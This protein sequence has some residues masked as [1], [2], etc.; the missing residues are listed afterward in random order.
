MKMSRLC[1][2][3]SLVWFNFGVLSKPSVVIIGAGP[4][5]IA[6]A[7]KLLQNGIHDI[8]ILEAEDRIGGR[9][10]SLEFGGGI[11]DL[12]AQYCHGEKG[13][14][15]YNLAKD[16]DVL[17]P[18][19]RSLQN[20]VYYSNGSKLNPELI[21]ELRQVYLKYDKNEGF[22]TKGKSL[23]EVFIQKYNSTLFPKYQNSEIEV[24]R[25]GLRFLEGYVLIHEG[26]FSWFNVSAD[27]DYVQCEGNQALIWK[28]GYKTVLK[29]M[30]QNTPIDSK[31]HLK[32]KVDKINWNNNPVTISASNQTFSGD[33]VI[34]TPSIGV[35]KR[36]KDTLFDPLLPPEKVKSIEATGF[37]GVM[38]VFLHFP[39][40]WWGDSDQAFAFFW[41]QKD[42]KLIWDKPWVTQIRYI[43]KV[44]HNSNV[45]VVWITGDLV[46]E[47]EK[48]PLENFKIGMKFVLERFLDR[49]YNVTEIG[50]VLR[51]NW[52]TNP[53]FGGTYSFTRVGFY[54][55]GVSHQEKLGE[56]LEGGSGRPVVLFA[57]E[58]THPEHFQTVHG[59]I[60]TGFREAER[61]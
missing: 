44:P 58:A 56:P 48:L 33:F 52:C 10:N 16:L 2:L 49:E 45:W 9:I 11:V 6:A 7:T 28:G 26:A 34:F 39:Q 32:T 46:P 15:A 54:E 55:K 50:D 17:E 8:K 25:E 21:E 12:G 40:K 30:M 22:E 57:G 5:G 42:L 35:L 60:E 3:F 53:N 37:E 38:K 18:G 31:I 1:V 41:S 23:G 36:E 51:S 61:I 19:L 13:N 29:I 20:N 4:S 47:I 24:L 59:A 43:L 27:C 14:V